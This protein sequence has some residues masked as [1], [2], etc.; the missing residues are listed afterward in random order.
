MAEVVDVSSVEGQ[1]LAGPEASPP[2]TKKSRRTVKDVLADSQSR[3]ADLERQ[4]SAARGASALPMAASPGGL[5]DAFADAFAASLGGPLAGLQGAAFPPA[6]RAVAVAGGVIPPDLSGLRCREQC[7]FRGAGKFCSA[8]GAQ[9]PPAAAASPSSAAQEMRIAALESLLTQ[10]V[11]AKEVSLAV[12]A[13]AVPPPRARGAI[14]PESGAP[15]GSATQRCAA[16]VTARATGAP[17]PV[18]EVFVADFLPSG[19]HSKNLVMVAAAALAVSEILPGLSGPLGKT[20]G[21][22]ARSPPSASEALICL[23]RVV[24]AL[25]LLPDAATALVAAFDKD[26][27]FRTV[28]EV[29]DTSGFGAPLGA[30]FQRSQ[31]LDTGHSDP[32]LPPNQCRLYAAGEECRNRASCQW[33]HGRQPAKRDFRGTRL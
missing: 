7:D 8:C 2:P 24:D 20:M 19:P 32:R 4:L 17:L 30:H 29:F 9:P 3:V 28:S 11:A 10:L 12:P 6:R 14:N 16:L 27:V 15:K 1:P 31:Q 25:I 21:R 13:A 22:I 26:D 18:H 33:A 5:A 23:Q